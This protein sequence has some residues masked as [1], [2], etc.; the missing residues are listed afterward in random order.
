MKWFENLFKKEEITEDEKL[1]KRHQG[2][3]FWLTLGWLLATFQHNYATLSKYNQGETLDLSWLVAGFTL[4]IA[5]ISNF[6]GVVVLEISLFWSIMFIPAGKRWNVKT[7]ILFLIMSV[8]TAVSIFL[9]A[10]YMYEASPSPGIID[11]GIGV[12]VGALMPVMV[13]LFGYVEGS[14]VNSRMGQSPSRAN[15]G[16]T[17]EQVKAAVDKDPFLTQRKAAERFGVSLGKMNKIYAQIREME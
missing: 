3:I 15:G 16:V 17:V 9:N 10:K 14:V 1:F 5:D 7:A 12:I 6:V 4:P 13:V 11:I 2:W 8:L